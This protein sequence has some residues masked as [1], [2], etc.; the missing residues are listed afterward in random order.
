[1]Y[2]VL[3]STEYEIYINRICSVKP[4]VASRAGARRARDRRQRLQIV[5]GHIRI[6]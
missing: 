3:Y 4:R 6:D 2:R 1:M 5:D